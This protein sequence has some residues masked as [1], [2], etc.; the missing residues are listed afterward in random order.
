MPLRLI[1]FK[2]TRLRVGSDHI[3]RERDRRSSPPHHHLASELR[4]WRE[5]PLVRSWLRIIHCSILCCCYH[6]LGHYPG[7]TRR[8]RPWLV[9]TSFRSFP[10]FDDVASTEFNVEVETCKVVCPMP[11][12]ATCLRLLVINALGRCLGRSHTECGIGNLT[13]AHG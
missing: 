8:F 13:V 6:T 7:P 4:P 9:S 11:N 5:T 3:L 2:T 12:Q 10:Q 1:L